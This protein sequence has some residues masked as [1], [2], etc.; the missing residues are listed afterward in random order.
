MNNNVIPVNDELLVIKGK[1]GLVNISQWQ[2]TGKYWARGTNT[3]SRTT[4]TR[5]THKVFKSRAKEIRK[6]H[7]AKERAATKQQL[8]TL[9]AQ[10]SALSPLGS[11]APYSGGPLAI[12]EDFVQQIMRASSP[13]EIVYGQ[14]F[15]R[16]V[17]NSNIPLFG[18]YVMIRSSE[19][20][21]PSEI[22]AELN[23]LHKSGKLKTALNKVRKTRK[24]LNDLNAMLAGLE[25]GGGKKRKT[26]HSTRRRRH[27]KHRHTKRK[28]HRGTRRH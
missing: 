21:T 28:T 17:L 7:L 9:S 26:L 11:S 8:N 10:L 16:G 3:K 25:V 22:G 27:T 23:V 1:E 14:K 2:N 12:N 13:N 18:E 15:S 19:G 20:K 6:A 5:G 4:L 24:N